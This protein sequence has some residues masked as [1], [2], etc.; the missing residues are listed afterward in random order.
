V[1]DGGCLT[2]QGFDDKHRL[3][4]TFDNVQFDSPPQIK[5]AAEHADLKFGA[6]NLKISG[7]DVSV[8]SMPGSGSP[9]ACRDKFVPLPVR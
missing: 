2:L 8:S 4:M 6:V 1:L 3:G 7:E 9:N 5:V